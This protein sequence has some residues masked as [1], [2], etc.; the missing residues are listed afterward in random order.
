VTIMN[1]QKGTSDEDD[2]Y[3]CM[4][5]HQG[6]ESTLTVNAADPPAMPKSTFTV[7]FRNVHYLSAGATQYGNKAAVAYQYTGMTYAPPWEHTGT[8]VNGRE[9]KQCAFCHMQRGSHSFEPE[10]VTICTQCHGNVTLETLGP[11]D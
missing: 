10:V 5:C 1:G 8:V 11:P 7:S 3:L 4:T 2:S 9:T 6:R